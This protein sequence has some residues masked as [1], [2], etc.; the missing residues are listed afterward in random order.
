MVSDNPKWDDRRRERDEIPQSSG[1]CSLICSP[2]TFMTIL[3]MAS[4]A[5]LTHKQH[6]TNRHL[7]EL[8][9]AVKRL[10]KM[11]KNYN[12]G[13]CPLKFLH[14]VLNLKFPSGHV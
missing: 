8:V 5:F 12:K 6:E 4:V 7:E 1:C 2:F 11:K 3:F 10:Q 14:N 13:S 9:S